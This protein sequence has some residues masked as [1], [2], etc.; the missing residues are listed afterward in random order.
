MAAPT[1]QS[2]EQIVSE[3]APVYQ[4]SIDVVNQ[5]RAQLPQ[6][7]DAQRQALGAEKVQ[8]FNQINNQMTGRGISFSGITADEQANYL[9][10]KYLPGLT[11]LKQQENEQNL[12]LDEA[13][14]KINQDRQSRA[15]DTRQKQQSS[16]E[17]YLAEERQRAWE[18]QKFQAEQA[19]ER[20]RMA[21]QA[22]IAAADRQAQYG[23]ASTT[24][25][26]GDIAKTFEAKKGRDKFVSPETFRSEMQ[27]WMA[28]GGS[29][30]SFTDAFGAYINPV[31]QQN[32]GGY[33]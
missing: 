22:S 11:S 2:V 18:Q 16:L 27:K 15:I 25:L 31:H 1:V 5:R 7:F 9:S 17:S 13:L 19:M 8:G 3:L 29:P 10:T 23:G 6:M 24:G 4:G 30:A 33:Y 14:A 21:Q 12:S 26:V 20:A 32:F 28:A